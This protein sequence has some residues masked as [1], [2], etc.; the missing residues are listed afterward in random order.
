[1]RARRKLDWDSV[2]DSVRDSARGS[3][4]DSVGDSVGDSVRDSVGDSARDS[5]GDSVRDSVGDSV[6]DTPRRGTGTSKLKSVR[7]DLRE[8]GPF[9]N[10]A[11]G[12]AGTLH[13][14]RWR[15]S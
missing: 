9:A 2:G 14:L 13:P 11:P 1:M 10:R 6:R 5:V 7:G 12:M 15:R 4:R 3:V 8:R